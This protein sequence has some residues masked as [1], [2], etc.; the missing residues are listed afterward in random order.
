MLLSALDSSFICMLQ[1]VKS[2]LTCRHE[3]CH[4]AFLTSIVHLAEN[5]VYVCSLFE[6]FFLLVYNDETEFCLR[7]RVKAMRE[8]VQM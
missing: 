4:Y 6:E 5:T 8:F 2:L 7:L 1:S 3:L